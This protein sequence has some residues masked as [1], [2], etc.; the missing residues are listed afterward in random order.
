MD[1]LISHGSFSIDEEYMKNIKKDFY[2]KKITDKETL[3]IIK[4]FAEKYNFIVD[5]HTAT[6]IGASK[7][8]KD[9]NE[10]LILGTAHPYKF[11]DTIKLATSKE[12]TKP[13]Q[14]REFN[15]IVEVPLTIDKLC[16]Y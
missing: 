12:V 3:N 14:I 10:I 8:V 16:S 9:N 11:L 2:A 1:Q 6:A 5:P 13:K 4:E 15:F 7:K